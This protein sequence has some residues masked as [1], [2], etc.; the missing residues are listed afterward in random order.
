VFSRRLV[1]GLVA[2]SVALVA[3]C[4]PA[5]PDRKPTPAPS[6]SVSPSVS[7]RAAAERDALV[8]YSAMWQAMAKAGEVPDPDAPELRQYAADQAL[9]RI[10]SAL[11][12]YRQTGVVTHGAPTTNP[13]VSDASPAD[14]PTEVK[15]IDC[16][17]STN[18]TKHKKAT[19]ELIKDDP[20]GRRNITA[21]VK[22]VDGTWKVTSFDVGDIGSC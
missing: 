5:K 16:A 4:G 7:A 1:V 8:A 14:A 12:T 3:G 21:V 2:M 20:R 19:G 11:F 15:V 10:V 17:D 18:W 13:R 22:S 6:P 9:A